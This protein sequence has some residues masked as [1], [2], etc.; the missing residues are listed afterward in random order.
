MDG[1]VGGWVGVREEV[2]DPVAIQI[3]WC[4]SGI[5][6]YIYASSVSSIIYYNFLLSPTVNIVMASKNIIM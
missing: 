4:F 2:R 5:M 3:M 6:S 1:L